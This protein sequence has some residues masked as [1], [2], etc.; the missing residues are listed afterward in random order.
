MPLRRSDSQ[1]KKVFAHAFRM[2]DEICSS[3]VKSLVAVSENGEE[4]SYEIDQ[5]RYTESAWEMWDAFCDYCRGL[6]MQRGWDELWYSESVCERYNGKSLPCAECKASNCFF[7]KEY[8][9]SLGCWETKYMEYEYREKCIH[10]AHPV[11]FEDFKKQSGYAVGRE[12]YA[13]RDL[14]RRFSEEID[15]EEFT[16]Q[17]CERMAQYIADNRELVLEDPLQCVNIFSRLRKN[18]PALYESSLK[19][20]WDGYDGKSENERQALDYFAVLLS[21]E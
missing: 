20:L 7:L 15:K 16:E 12:P 10:L 8:M 2:P 18:A 3:R 5:T 11:S 4:F 19:L 14:Y 1:K 6:G 13:G 17:E 9:E 21:D